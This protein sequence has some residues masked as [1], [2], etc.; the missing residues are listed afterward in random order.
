MAYI[1]QVLPGE[2]QGELA[3]LYDEAVQRA[4]RV[5]RIL[6]LQSLNPAVLSASLEMYKAIMFGPSP[7]SRVEREAIAVT[8]SRANDCFY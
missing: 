5:Y 4:G 3:R 8:V 7:L 6:V 1:R 2:A